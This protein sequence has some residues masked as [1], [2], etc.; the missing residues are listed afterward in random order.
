M[1]AATKPST[2]Q[3]VVH[4]ASTLTDET[5]RNGSIKKNPEKIGNGGE[6]SKDRNGRDDNKRTRTGNAFATT[7]N[8]IRREYIGTTPK[9]IACNYHHSP[10]T[11]CRTCFNY[12]R[13]GHFAKDCKVVPKNV[14]PINA[15]NPTA[16]ACYECGSTD[17]VKVAC[18][19]LNQAQRPGGNHQ[20][21]AVAVNGGLGRGNNGNQARGRAFM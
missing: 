21:Q 15:R 7:A 20:N 3:K 2:I 19:R 18:P 5:L 9:C 8:P 4:I 14:N 11:P 1:V 17:H 6:P 10:E 16:R 12:N 13:P